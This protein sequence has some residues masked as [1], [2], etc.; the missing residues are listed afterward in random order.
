MNEAVM[1]MKISN[2][3]IEGSESR[4]K[5]ISDGK[6]TMEISINADTRG[7]KVL[8]SKYGMT[9]K[10]WYVTFIR[11]T[12]TSMQCVYLRDDLLLART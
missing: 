1:K 2:C 6:G 4:Q 5:F 8:I 11:L 12:V 3:E 9:Q 7:T 10:E